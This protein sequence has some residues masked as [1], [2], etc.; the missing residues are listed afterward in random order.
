[1]RGM[2]EGRRRQLAIW[3]TWTPERRFEAAMA[4]TML[5]LELRDQ[6]L[7]AQHPQAT[8]SEL[9][10]LRVEATLEASPSIR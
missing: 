5:V 2:D 4:M 7:A 8:E 9:R 1:M 3:R 10:S 6:R